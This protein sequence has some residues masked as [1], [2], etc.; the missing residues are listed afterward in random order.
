MLQMYKL[1]LLLKTVFNLAPGKVQFDKTEDSK[2]QHSNLSNISNC[3]FLVVDQEPTV[4]CQEQK[5]LMSNYTRLVLWYMH[6]LR[7]QYD[8]SF[9]FY[10]FLV[11]ITDFYENRCVL[12]NVSK[13]IQLNFIFQ[14]KINT[15]ILYFKV[16]IDVGDCHGNIRVMILFFRLS[17]HFLWF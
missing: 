10:N 7:T 3:T 6:L 16:T 14:P 5:Q 17:A 2:L 15:P 1:N 12:S 9:I 8:I 13:L 11:S 4:A